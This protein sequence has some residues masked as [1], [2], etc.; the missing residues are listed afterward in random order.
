MRTVVVRVVRCGRNF[1]FEFE[2][3]TLPPRHGDQG[4][5]PW[6]S[7]LPPATVAPHLACYDNAFYDFRVCSQLQSILCRSKKPMRSARL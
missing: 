7:H 6:K 4:K 2:E 1:G 5:T 3:Q